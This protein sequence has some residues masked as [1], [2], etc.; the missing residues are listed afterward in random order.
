VAVNVPDT[1]SDTSSNTNRNHGEKNHDKAITAQGHRNRLLERY[2]KNGVEALHPHELLELLLTYS[3]HRRDTK[4][5]AHILLKRY[6]T[7]SAVCN[8]STEELRKID[9]IGQ[10]SAA[11]LVLM[12]DLLT[13]CLKERFTRGERIGHWRD[14]ASYLRMTFGYRTD[15]YVAAL[16][17]DAANRVIQTEIVAEGTVNQCA[18][19]PRKIIE[20]ALHCH[21]I[22]F[23]IAHN[24][25]GGTPNPSESDWQITD[26]LYS[27]GKLLD[28]L[29][30]DHI[31]VCS[32]T[33]VS[34]Q[35]MVRW[36]GKK[37]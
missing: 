34:L 13:T 30:V 10:K 15:E 22:S 26:R 24:H 1:H 6:K 31:L 36:P 17:L 7:I 33:V 23:I 20:H 9:G 11:L 32:D 16:F 3:I 2:M 28:I 25:P 37:R 27:A 4:Q 12:R 21:A 19:Y 5:I 29:L 35:D 14:V 8:A 18:L